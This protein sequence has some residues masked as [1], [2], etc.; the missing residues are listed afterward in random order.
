[1][2]LGAIAGSGA[3]HAIEPAFASRAHLIRVA[4]V[5]AGAAVL[6]IVCERH[7]LARAFFLARSAGA[8]ASRSSARAAVG[9]GRAGAS[10]GC[11][12]AAEAA[13]R[14]RASTETDAVARVVVRPT[15]NEP[16]R[17]PGH[18]QDTH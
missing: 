6:R 18:R 7:A 3:P 8:G 12:R 15:S 2:D 10:P 16:R 11:A 14:S 1:S 5:A 9:T 4:R 17:Q 13:R